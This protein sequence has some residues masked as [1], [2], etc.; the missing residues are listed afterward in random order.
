MAATVG[1]T[2][3]IYVTVKPVR[4]YRTIDLDLGAPVVQLP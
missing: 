2:M 3:E 1:V 4:L